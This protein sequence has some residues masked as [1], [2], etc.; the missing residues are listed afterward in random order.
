MIARA[1]FL[2]VC[3]LLA[4]GCDDCRASSTATDAGNEEGGG[5][6]T[7]D[8]GDAASARASRSAE[9]KAEDAWLDGGVDPA[10]TGTA[11]DLAAAVVDA[12]CAID[13]RMAKALRAALEGDAGL[14]SLKQ[15]AKRT[16]D[17]K[18]EVR[19]VNRGAKG[20]VLPLSFHPNVPAFM[21]LAD[22]A[23]E[24]AVYEL[25]TPKLEVTSD[26]G[27]AR[28]ARVLVPP[29]GALVARIALNPHVA[30]RIDKH[31]A[32]PPPSMLAPGRWTLHVAQL[33]CDV[34][35]GEPAI[36]AWD[37]EAPH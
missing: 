34:E 15:E 6:A 2:V 19:V 10:C 5:S 11:I 33:V 3:A 25:E 4:S 27:G 24:K 32:G 17:G 9:P 12:R 26:A 22:S 18:I 1:S 21:V 37:V 31:D 20:V 8:G 14:L 35:A 28:F 16:A 30:R 23:A 29:G 36:V 13:S 7:E